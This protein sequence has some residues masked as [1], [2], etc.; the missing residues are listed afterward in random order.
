[1]KKIIIA[2]FL[3]SSGL[4]IACDTAPET[5]NVSKV[6]NYPVFDY[7][8]LVVVPLNGTFNTPVSV[9]ENGLSIEYTTGGDDVDVTQVGVYNVTYSATNVDGFSANVVQT[10]VVHDPT[11]VGTNVSGNIRD[12]NNNARKGVISLVP[13]TTSIFFCTDFGFAGAFPMYFKMDG[14][15]I[16]EINQHYF[17]DVTTVALTYDPATL[18]FTTLISPYGFGYTFE[19]Y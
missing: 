10:V 8:E 4:F 17:F 18:Q 6:T 7:E 9:S 5:A 2:L 11:I 14:N 15:T 13:G 1:M 19:Y 3:V 16:S 12:K